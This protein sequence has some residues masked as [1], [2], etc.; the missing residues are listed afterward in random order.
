[1]LNLF[2]KIIKENGEGS[3]EFIFYQLY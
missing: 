2:S 3:I 1:M